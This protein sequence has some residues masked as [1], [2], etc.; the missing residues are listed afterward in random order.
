MAASKGLL[1]HSLLSIAAR[2]T[3]VG[4]NFGLQILIARL[5]TLGHYGDIKMLLTLVVAGGL[6]SRLGVEQLMVKEI[7]SVE[8]DRQSFGSQF[9]KKSY[10]VVVASSIVFIIQGLQK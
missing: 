7:A 1:L 5:L 2:F 9:L 3:G 8:S 4:L 10:M 6:F